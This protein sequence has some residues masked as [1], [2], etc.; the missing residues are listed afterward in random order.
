MQAGTPK[1]GLPIAQKATERYKGARGIRYGNGDITI[2]EIENPDTR[3][4]IKLAILGNDSTITETPP[5]SWYITPV[6]R[7]ADN[8]MPLYHN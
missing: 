1:G 7:H 6:K 5:H 8:Y 3:T 4:K 2:Q